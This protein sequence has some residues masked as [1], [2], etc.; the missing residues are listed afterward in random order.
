MASSRA[1]PSNSRTSYWQTATV[2]DRRSW[3]FTAAG[4]GRSE[5]RRE[6]FSPSR[7]YKPGGS[8]P[9]RCQ[10]R[11]DFWWREGRD[12]NPRGSFT[13]PTR[14][15]GGCFRPLSHLPGESRSP[16]DSNLTYTLSI[17]V[18]YTHLRAHETRHELV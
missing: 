17:P 14:L 2:G 9:V 8:P 18:S 16:F 11:P 7:C 12:S 4:S 1:G 6:C 10:P 13:P 5:D 15:A 3:W